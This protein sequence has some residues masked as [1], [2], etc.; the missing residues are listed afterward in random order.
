VAKTP[1]GKRYKTYVGTTKN[2]QSRHADYL[3]NGDHI[4]HFME[5][6]VKSG[7][8]IMRR[9]RYIIPKPLLAPGQAGLA[10]VVAEQAET[11]FLGKFNYAWNSRQNGNKEMTRM[12]VKTPFM[13]FFSR[14]RWVRH[15]GVQKFI[16]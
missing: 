7:F 8:F 3:R 1:G 10:A 2:L 9:V 4:A 11:R 6:A 5:S 13:C 16:E 15:D 12:P 14:I